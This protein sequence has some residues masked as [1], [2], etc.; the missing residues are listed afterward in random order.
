MDD[1]IVGAKAIAAMTGL[2]VGQVYYRAKVGKLPV[3]KRGGRWTASRSRLL[4]HY[5][6]SLRSLYSPLPPHPTT[7][8]ASVRLYAIGAQVAIELGL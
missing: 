3:E 8:Y 5:S 7:G 1:L 6:V 2:T 4:A